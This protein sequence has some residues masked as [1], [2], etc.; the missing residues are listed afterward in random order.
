MLELQLNVA[1]SSW[2]WRR[3]SSCNVACACRTCST[4]TSPSSL[5][6]G[7]G[8]G[9]FLLLLFRLFGVR[10]WQLEC[11]VDKRLR[12]VRLLD[13]VHNLSLGAHSHAIHLDDLGTDLYASRLPEHARS[14]SQRGSDAA[15]ASERQ[16]SRA[17][18]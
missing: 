13:L 2:S 4:A 7:L 16:S 11:P 17:S 5:P 10:R 12:P 18:V 9:C 6:L 8:S 14:A 1:C 15:N 3:R